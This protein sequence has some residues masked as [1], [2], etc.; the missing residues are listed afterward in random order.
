MTK[1]SAILILVLV[2]ATGVLINLYIPELFPD[3]LLI[4]LGLGYLTGLK[5]ADDNDH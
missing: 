4:A 5:Y 2:S 1:L 3:Y